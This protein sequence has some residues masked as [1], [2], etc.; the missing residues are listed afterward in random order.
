MPAKDVKP[1]KLFLEDGG[2]KG[3]GTHVRII[4]KGAVTSARLI[5]HFN[6]NK[7]VRGGWFLVHVPEKM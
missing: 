7:I 6:Y 5:L 1:L 2:E 3:R 4:G